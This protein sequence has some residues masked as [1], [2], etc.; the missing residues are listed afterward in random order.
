MTFDY[1]TNALVLIPVYLVYDRAILTTEILW[2][3][4]GDLRNKHI[5][6]FARCLQVFATD[7]LICHRNTATII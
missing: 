3:T 4:P 2:T 6:T 5:H 1:E 7:I